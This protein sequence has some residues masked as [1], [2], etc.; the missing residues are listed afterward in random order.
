MIGPSPHAAPATVNHVVP[1]DSDGSGTLADEYKDGEDQNQT[2]E[3]SMQA[4]VPLNNEAPFSTNVAWEREP[5][6]EQGNT[7]VWG[8]E[9]RR[10]GELST[11]VPNEDVPMDVEVVRQPQAP[12]RYPIPDIVPSGVADRAHLVRVFREAVIQ[13]QIR[14]MLERDNIRIGQLRVNAH[15]IRRIQLDLAL[16]NNGRVNGRLY[17]LPE[18]ITRQDWNHRTGECFYSVNLVDPAIRR[19]AETL[20]KEFSGVPY[21]IWEYWGQRTRVRE[22]HV[23]RYVF[24]NFG[25]YGF[26]RVV[27]WFWLSDQEWLEL[28]RTLQASGRV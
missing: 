25:R 26:Y 14:G 2:G 27:M 15:N 19:T 3:S 13:G 5:S 20:E 28:W 17:L 8:Q 6:V 23:H 1:L 22:A 7:S 18:N 9:D 11:N 21:T 24:G 16:R 4:G 10:M 12:E